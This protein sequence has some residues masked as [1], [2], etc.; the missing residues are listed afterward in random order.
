MKLGLAIGLLCLLLLLVVVT[1]ARRHPW[2]NP[3]RVPIQATTMLFTV[4]NK[5]T[6]NTVVFPRSIVLS[7]VLAVPAGRPE[8]F[9]GN[10]VS[11]E[12]LSEGELVFAKNYSL[13]SVQRCNWLDREGLDGFFLDNLE[14]QSAFIKSACMASN[15]TFSLSISNAAIG[16]TV[17][18][19]YRRL[20]GWKP[21]P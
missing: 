11:V 19:K 2:Q 7:L 8:P 15:A 3:L 6:S 14:D 16:S 17:W 12:I 21:L 9:G 4:T 1:L 10:D 20:S 18:L 5:T 13:R